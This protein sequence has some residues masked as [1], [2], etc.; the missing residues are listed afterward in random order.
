MPGPQE[1]S[2]A[3]RHGAHRR[4]E[5]RRFRCVWALFRDVPLPDIAFGNDGEELMAKLDERGLVADVGV[6]HHF[7]KT[8]KDVELPP[9]SWPYAFG[10]CLYLDIKLRGA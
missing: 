6:M 9:G 2:D 1:Q 10:H 3:D 4:V 8:P 5:I 7:S